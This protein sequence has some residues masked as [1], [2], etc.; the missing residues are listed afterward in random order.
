MKLTSKSEYTLLALIFMARKPKGSYVKIEEICQ[1]YDI[2]KKYL[3]QLLTIMRSNG[4]VKTRR[5]AE[6]GYALAKDSRDITAADIVR[7]MDG[8]IAPTDSV[9]RY[10]YQAT[11]LEKEDTALEL[12]RDIRDYAAKVMESKT[13]YDLAFAGAQGAGK[14]SHIDL[15]CK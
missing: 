7:I 2:P 15:V 13:L 5:G 6:G 10:F 11:P 12:F 4:L 3:E 14:Y 9:S 8:P 1:A